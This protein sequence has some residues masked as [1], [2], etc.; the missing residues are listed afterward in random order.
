MNEANHIVLQEKDKDGDYAP[1]G[2]KQ[3]KLTFMYFDLHR[4][5]KG[6]KALNEK[7]R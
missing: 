1:N 3:Y 5:L 7:N 4:W 2:K 6:E